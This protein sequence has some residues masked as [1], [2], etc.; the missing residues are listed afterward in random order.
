MDIAL[1]Y[2]LESENVLYYERPLDEPQ[3]SCQW[4]PLSILGHESSSRRS[5]RQKDE[6]MIGVIEELKYD[7]LPIK[8]RW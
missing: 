3:A 6:M 2:R 4:K 5:V 1:W 8:A 7:A